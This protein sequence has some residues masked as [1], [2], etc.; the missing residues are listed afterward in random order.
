MPPRVLLNF[1]VF[2]PVYG[3]SVADFCDWDALEERVRCPK[4]WVVICVKIRYQ[5]VPLNLN[6]LTT[7]TIVKMGIF[8][9][10]EKSPW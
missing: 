10:Q 1:V 7:Q 6:L 9:Y 5:D 3:Y 8:P 4:M 2:P